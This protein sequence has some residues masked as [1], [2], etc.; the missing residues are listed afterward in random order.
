MKILIKILCLSV[1]WF[2]C[3]SDV[4]GCTDSEA[5]NFNSNANSDDN[6]CEYESCIG[7]TDL[8]A[9]N[10]D[11]YNKIDDGSCEYADYIIDIT[12]TMIDNRAILIEY[13]E[14]IQWNNKTNDSMQIQFPPNSNAFITSCFNSLNDTTLIGNPGILGFYEFRADSSA[15]EWCDSIFDLDINMVLFNYEVILPNNINYEDCEDV[16]FTLPNLEFLDTI[17]TNGYIFLY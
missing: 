4:N 6:T 14:T 1:L 5:C 11:S 15:D 13:G 10:Y 12:D 7:C 2:S 3:E 9:L 17:C 8:Y 16:N